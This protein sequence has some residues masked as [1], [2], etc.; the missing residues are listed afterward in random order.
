MPTELVLL[1]DVEPTSEA[2]VR[3]ASVEHPLGTFL[4]YRD[5][6]IRQFVDAEGQAL[7]QVYR[8]RPVSV[9]REAAAAVQDP[10]QSF[11]LW[12]DLA[13]P[14]GAPDTAR[15]LAEAIAEAVGGVIR[16]R[17]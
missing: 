16:E 10:P 2:M 6:Q 17:A 8:T 14:Y 7:L 15:A 13:V 12:T 5:G 9:P 4:E 1:S 3:A 11:A